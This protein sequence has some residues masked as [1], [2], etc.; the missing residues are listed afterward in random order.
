MYLFWSTISLRLS[1]AW[2]VN[3]RNEFVWLVTASRIEVVC[4]VNASRI[5]VVCPDNACIE[6]VCSVPASFNEV[7]AASI[8][9][10]CLTASNRWI[11]SKNYHHSFMLRL[12]HDLGRHEGVKISEG[13][14]MCVQAANSPSKY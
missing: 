8:E 9:A 3:A 4:A 13:I 6:V 11:G 1:V 14:P 12:V 10:A 7:I 2:S 5:E